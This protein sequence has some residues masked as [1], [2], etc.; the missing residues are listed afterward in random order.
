MQSRLLQLK[1]QNGHGPIPMRPVVHSNKD[2]AEVPGTFKEGV[3]K[4][5]F[6]VPIYHDA[7][8]GRQKRGHDADATMVGE[9]CCG[10]HG[11]R[12]LLLPRQR[13]HVHDPDRRRPVRGP[14]S[15]DLMGKVSYIFW[16]SG[17]QGERKDDPS[18][19]YVGL[20]EFPAFDGSK[21]ASD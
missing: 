7:G 9:E 8:M 6:T 2:G 15:R 11:H 10:I 12:G 18:L 16:A 13:C 3:I 17:I 19:G 1:P 21:D 14:G 5:N 20:D 4:S